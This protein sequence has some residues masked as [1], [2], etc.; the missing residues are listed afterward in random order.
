MFGEFA[1]QMQDLFHR[2]QR[3]E[4]IVQ[5]CRPRLND[6]RHQVDCPRLGE[7]R[8]VR[9]DPDTHTV[10]GDDALRKGIVGQRHRVLVETLTQ[11]RHLA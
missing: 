8:K 5:V 11:L 6:L 2:T 10:L 1:R 7:H 4:V 3:L 9:V